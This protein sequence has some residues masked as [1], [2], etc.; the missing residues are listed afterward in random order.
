MSTLQ[1]VLLGFLEGLTEFIPVSS[2][3]HLL[4]VGHFLGF[5]S[6]GRAFEDGLWNAENPIPVAGSLR[7]LLQSAV[8]HVHPGL[9]ASEEADDWDRVCD[10]I[11]RRV[12][13][14]PATPAYFDH[15]ATEGVLSVNAAWTFT[16]KDDAMKRAHLRIWKPVMK[17][18][19]R[20]LTW[21]DGDVPIVFLLLGDDA[22]TLFRA[23]VASSFRS[24]AIDGATRLATVYCDHPAYQ[25]G[26]PYFACGNPM[27]RVNQALARLGSR[28]VQW[29]PDQH[30][31]ADAQE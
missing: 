25:G 10:A 2:T 12:I 3:G 20:K 24:D 19:L 1:V 16:G 27:R 29:W 23:T 28:E 7:R 15:L 30:L 22:R 13:P 6:T 5:K 8:A 9:G 4:L 31:G 18:L 14:S 11:R 17:H 21:R 26:R